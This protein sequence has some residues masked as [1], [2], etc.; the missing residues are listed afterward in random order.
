MN[1]IWL[2]SISLLLLVGCATEAPDAKQAATFIEDF[3]EKT[4]KGNFENLSDYYSEEMKFGESDDVREEK[5]KKLFDVMGPVEKFELLETQTDDDWE[6]P[7]VTL[8]YK[9]VHSSM[10]S[11][12][13][14]TV[15]VERKG[16]KILRQNVESSK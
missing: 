3:L 4:G 2:C 16:Y 7:T 11:I 1:K 12:E 5:M 9:V 8:V 6:R 13:T 15:K 10:T 14:Y